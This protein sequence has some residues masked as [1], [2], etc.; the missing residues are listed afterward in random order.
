M[1]LGPWPRGR[2]PCV[3]VSLQHHSCMS[4]DSL[5]FTNL[6]PLPAQA[7]Q[8][9]EKIAETEVR[10]VQIAQLPPVEIYWFRIFLGNYGVRAR[11][12]FARQVTQ[13]Y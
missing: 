5:G 1:G 12:I 11:V 3:P 6:G 8:D 10:V 4:L 9:T 2:G 13:I 7:W